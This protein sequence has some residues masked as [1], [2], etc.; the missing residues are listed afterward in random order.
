M[1][2][3]LIGF[4][5]NDDQAEHARDDLR[6]AGFDWKEIHMYRG[7]R[8]ADLWESA[9]GV[10]RKLYQEASRRGAT[11]VM[12]DLDET[13]ASAQEALQILRRHHPMGMARATWRG[14]GWNGSMQPQR[15]QGQTQAQ[16]QPQARQAQMQP[17][18]QALTQPQ[19][20]TQAQPRMQQPTMPQPHVRVQPRPQPQRAAEQQPQQTES[21]SDDRIIPVIED[22]MMPSGMQT[23][24]AEQQASQQ[25]SPPQPAQE[26][27][28]PAH[29]DKEE[30]FSAKRFATELAGDDR[31]TGREWCDIEPYV[32]KEF[33]RRFPN[34]SWDERSDAIV[35]A[36]VRECDQR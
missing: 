27:P 36:Y 17:Q 30:I 35:L 29:A 15:Q 14:Q 19:A 9:G 32:R 6:N 10:D 20:Q 1:T 3:K 11:A 28:A 22:N 12:L 18:S 8:E 13:A 31:F 26:P 16:P 25:S 33:E 21:E 24:G 7:G 5:Q 34:D 4:Y 2:P 23:E